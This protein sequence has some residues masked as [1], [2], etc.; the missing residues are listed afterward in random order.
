MQNL[1]GHIDGTT[2]IPTETISD[3][4][5][6]DKP[7]PN[8]A[9]ATWLTSDRSVCLLLQS[10]LSEEAMSEIIGISNA[11]QIWIALRTAYS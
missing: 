5:K 3:S 2:T 11:R 6:P 1:L 4:E 10:S 7:V 8:P 9:Y